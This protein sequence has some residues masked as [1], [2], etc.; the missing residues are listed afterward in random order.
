MLVISD[1]SPLIHLASVGQ[2]QLLQ[3][4]YHEIVVPQAVADELLF[5]T[6][7]LDVRE[8][9]ETATWIQTRSA[10]D[11]VLV[12]KLDLQ[13]DTGEA[14]AIALAIELHADLLLIDERK[15]RKAAR[16]FHLKTGGVLSVLM[17]AK[18]RK[19]I[20]EV[21]PLIAA[22]MDKTNFRVSEELLA[23]VRRLTKE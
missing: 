19:L 9:I 23:E 18:R 10:A 11:R 14:E 12:S 20:A 16:D 17:D 22:M 15:G 3:S 6:K 5:K 2:L 4:L 7:D 8:Q 1:T 21:L 13:L